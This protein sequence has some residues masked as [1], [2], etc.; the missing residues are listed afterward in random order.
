MSEDLALWILRTL[1]ICGIWWCGYFLGSYMGSRKERVRIEGKED[2]ISGIVSVI[3]IARYPVGIIHFSL[4]V[5]RELK[6]L[7]ERMRQFYEH[8]WQPKK[9]RS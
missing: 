6:E 5:E 3:P 7:R 4:G 2:M 8:E 1:A 9:G